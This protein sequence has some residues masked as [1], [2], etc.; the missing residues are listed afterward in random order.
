MTYRARK[1][2][3]GNP[4]EDCCPKNTIDPAP[5]EVISLKSRAGGD[6]ICIGYAIG[7]MSVIPDL[8]RIPY[9]QRSTEP[10]P[11]TKSKHQEEL[12][13]RTV[14]E[15]EELKQQVKLLE[16]LAEREAEIT[17]LKLQVA[18]E[19]EKVV[20]T[21]V[22]CLVNGANMMTDGCG[23][24]ATCSQCIVS[25]KTCP[26]CRAPFNSSKKI[27]LPGGVDD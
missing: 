16:F 23:H 13:Q 22:V 15:I 6:N 26:I 3:F 1:V 11:Q 27:Y 12:K 18:K 9:Y 5:A 4:E 10:E 14:A 19:P 2:Y 20:A 25:L 24:L 17:R 21:C 7:E 8:L